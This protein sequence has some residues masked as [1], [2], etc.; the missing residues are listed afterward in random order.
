MKKTQILKELNE[1]DSKVLSKELVELS[2]KMAKMRLDVAMRK[3]KNVKSIEDT[4]KR[5]ARIFTI[6][7]ERAITEAKT[8]QVK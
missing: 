5:V 3:L 4:R 7:N 6:L 2:H 8:A 1:K